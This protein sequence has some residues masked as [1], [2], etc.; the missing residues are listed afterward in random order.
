MRTRSVKIM[1]RNLRMTRIATWLALA[2]SLAL[3][4]CSGGGAPTTANALS[5][6]ATSSAAAY[7]GPAPATADVQAFEL[8]LWQNIRG[9]N[10][11]GACH[12]ATT[13]AQMPNFARS[14]DVN[15]AYAQ[16]NTV[17]NLS[18]PSTSLM[19]TKVSGGHNCWL[20]DPSAC[21]QILTTWITNW[22]NA[23]GSASATQ[24]QLVAPT[25]VAVGQSLNFPASYV[26][27][28][29]TIYNNVTSVYCSGCHSPAAATPQSP[30]FAAPVA[31]IANAYQAAIPKIDFTGC[32]PFN[33]TT[34]GTN[35]RFYQR[36]AVD[37][38]NCWSNCAQN[39]QFMLQ[40]IQAFAQMLTPTNIDPTLVV[41]K[42]LTLN[43]GTIASGA[44]RYDA[45]TIAKYE[46]QTGTGL[47]AYD[48]SGVDPS[49]D[50]TITGNVT[51]AGGWG[52]NVGAGGKLQATTAGSAKVYNLIQATGEFSIEAWV[53]PALVAVPDNSSF[54]VSYSGGDTARNFTLAQTNQ[55]YDFMLRTSSTNLDGV[56]ELATPTAADVLQAALQHVVLTYDPINGR[57][58]YVN[59]VNTGVTD[60][61]KGGTIS[62]W[63]SSFALVLGN[64]T[65][66]DKSWQG[67]IKFAAI[68]S[69]SLTAAQ[70]LQNYNA[71]VGERFYLLFDVSSVINVPQTYVMMTVSQYDSYS[72]LFDQ[73]TFISLN[74]SY[75]P[76][77]P[78]PIAG[79]SIGVNG[80]IPQVGQAYLPLNTTVTAS[81]YTSQGQVLSQVGT[82]IALQSGPLTDQ[83]FLSFNQLG[84]ATHVTVPATVVPQPILPGPT[85]AD[86]G[87][88]TFAEIN[89]TLSVLTGVPT[90]DTA[91]STTYQ[92][93]QQQLPAVYTLE[94]FSAA[95][96]VGVA[97]LA[98]QYC[99][100]AVN[101]PTYSAALFPG[102]TYNAS[103][104]SGSD[105]S[106]VASAL[107][108]K[109]LGNGQLA[110]APAAATVT[111]ELNNLITTLCS[112]S[113]CNTSARVQAVKAAACAAAFGSA[114]MLIK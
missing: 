33:A 59:G 89:S 85:V 80:L 1:K 2:G 66:T 39:A 10:R 111:T 32:V 72:Y 102:V 25:P 11:C 23:T 54:I 53:A 60:P 84:S 45:D 12:N 22:A 9:Q 97:Q 14:D 83:F 107:A 21:G 104:F 26:D 114:D 31:Q 42:A 68:H 19:V 46:F 94:S 98:I 100:E 50:M 6:P 93:V 29:T 91:V 8:N 112:T 15:L 4:A 30:Y 79:I 18:Q 71:G 48:T 95:N 41:S 36:L 81:S 103:T 87:V 76:S 20:A 3:A 17:V 44:N 5:A 82:V 63:D 110:S 61:Q 49:A 113:A 69:R 52:V 56:P 106:A 73:P 43:A 75:S 34:C 62:N 88:R 40:Q 27:Y 101:S 105:T 74:A 13:P 109:V 35:S 24:V 108:A 47:V 16:A 38:H 7:T 64:E 28:E 86:I 78:I 51:W 92:A 99:N 37:M 55:N 65:S 57:Q 58:I 67:L 70:V 96:Q 77:A 90:T